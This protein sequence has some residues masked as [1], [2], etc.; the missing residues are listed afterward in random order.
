[1]R[2][3]VCLDEKEY[4]NDCGQEERPVASQ[5]C[6]VKKCG[7]E[8]QGNQIRDM[9]DHEEELFED[10]AEEEDVIEEDSF[11]DEECLDDDCGDNLDVYTTISPVDTLYTTTS[12][13]NIAN[14]EMTEKAVE[15]STDSPKLRP[16][17]SNDVIVSKPVKPK[18]GGGCVDKFKNCNIVV[19]SRLC[20][21]TFYQTNC[22]RSCQLNT[23]QP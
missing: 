16:V 18:K 12:T 14:T 3:V 1:M 10:E 9:E 8:R 17:L 4:R 23:G 6:N 7:E 5:E 11:L 20:R 22:C 19:Q 15:T 13:Y 21:Y 2:D